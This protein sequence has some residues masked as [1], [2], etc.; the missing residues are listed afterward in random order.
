MCVFVCVCE[1][2]CVCVCVCVTICLCVCV[3]VCVKER[4]KK[5]QIE[6]KISLFPL[7]AKNNQWKRRKEPI[8]KRERKRKQF[9]LRLLFLF[10]FSSP[11]SSFSFSS[12]PN[13]N[14]LRHFSLAPMSSPGQF[15]HHFMSSFYARWAQKPKKRQS[16]QAACSAFGICARK[17]C[18]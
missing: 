7:T 13:K 3:C 10:T 11:S 14:V 16:T 9:S 2:K 4:E 18:L 17:S 15:H 12:I 6:L 5:G 1:F 8:I